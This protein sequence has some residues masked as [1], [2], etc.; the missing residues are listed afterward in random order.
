MT[1]K[2]EQ[3]VFE[4][5]LKHIE[6]EVLKEMRSSSPDEAKI[7][8]LVQDIKNTDIKLA[9]LRDNVLPPM[10]TKSIGELTPYLLAKVRWAHVEG[11]SLAEGCITINPNGYTKPNN[12]PINVFIALDVSNSMG[13]EPLI[14][15]ANETIKM[16]EELLSKGGE[17]MLTLVAYGRQSNV[18]VDEV[19]LSRE[20]YSDITKAIKKNVGNPY[21]GNIRSDTRFLEPLS[22]IFERGSKHGDDSVYIWWSDGKENGGNNDLP[23]TDIKSLVNKF[24]PDG[25]KGKMCTATYKDNCGEKTQMQEIT[26]MW[27]DTQG[28]DGFFVNVDNIKA[29][30]TFTKDSLEDCFFSTM[31]RDI[32]ITLPTGEV[33]EVENVRH[34]PIDITFTLPVT[35]EQR[36]GLTKGL[37]LDT[38]DFI[39]EDITICFN[40]DGATNSTF[41]YKIIDEVQIVVTQEVP[42]GIL[43]SS[44]NTHY[45]HKLKRFYE[46]QQ[47]ITGLTDEAERDLP[48]LEESL[49]ILH[50][51]GTW[52]SDTFHPC[53]KAQGSS[54][55]G[56]PRMINFAANHQRQAKYTYNDI[57]KSIIAAKRIITGKALQQ[58]Y[59]VYLSATRSCNSRAMQSY[60]GKS[61][62]GGYSARV[63]A[64]GS[65]NDSKADDSKAD[66]S[67]DDVSEDD[68]E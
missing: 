50:S 21:M 9:L 40:T 65:F 38:T 59:K 44:V 57:E 13:D 35:I 15:L 18:F 37:Y 62:S 5:L 30:V 6:A 28:C 33:R 51:A 10:E 64:Y 61:Q 26:N 36:V 25:P 67:E 58:D 31:A 12:K 11:S 32:I 52:S 48:L 27:D 54:P 23:K 60:C 39:H 53:L 55:I 47:M 8:S 1:T 7:K 45:A 43:V 2:M 29:I 4:N 46:L 22:D 3:Q 20:N 68:D 66:D 34:I 42:G 16:V 56:E 14:D 49:L 24:F 19:I 63:S 41:V 17:I